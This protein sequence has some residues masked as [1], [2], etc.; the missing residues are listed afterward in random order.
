MQSSGGDRLRNGH[1]WSSLIRSR[2]DNEYL[3]SARAASQHYLVLEASDKMNLMPISV[4][5]LS[6][7][8]THTLYVIDTWPKLVMGIAVFTAMYIPLCWNL[9]MNQY[10][11][12]LITKPI[13]NTL[14]R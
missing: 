6:L 5:A 12:N 13:L 2:L 4:T 11:R 9:S 8:I 14:R 1:F 7:F 10:E 3:L